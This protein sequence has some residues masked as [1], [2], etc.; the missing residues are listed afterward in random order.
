MRAPRI[1]RE[2]LQQENMN[3]ESK[4]FEAR[5]EAEA[6]EAE[7]AIEGPEREGLKSAE[8]VGKRGKGEDLAG[9]R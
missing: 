4:K 3:V 5:G 6:K 1:T 2:S 8:Q 7:R 9:N